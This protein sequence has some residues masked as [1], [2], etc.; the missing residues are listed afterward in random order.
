[1]SYTTDDYDI[2][3]QVSARQATSSGANSSSTQ[4]NV[5]TSDVATADR[6]AVSG[7]SKPAGPSFFARLIHTAEKLGVEQRGIERVPE[8]ERTDTGFKALMNVFTMWLSANMVVAAFALGLLA[9]SIFGLGVADS[10]LV[11][12]FFN[13]IGITPVCYFSTFGPKFGL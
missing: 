6:K 5:Q 13:L 1:M 11:I 10:M 9:K 7:A 3:K 2:E 12:L 4:S 8:D